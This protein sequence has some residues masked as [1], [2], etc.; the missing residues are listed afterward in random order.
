MPLQS[1]VIPICVTQNS[2]FFGTFLEKILFLTH[3][4]QSNP[5]HDRHIRKAVHLRIPKIRL[6]F[7]F[8]HPMERQI[9]GD[10]GGLDPALILA[11][12]LKINVIAY[13]LFLKLTFDYSRT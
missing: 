1:Q 13:F 4:D 9:F 6:K 5:P 8:R 7:D 11:L 12:C 3:F 10:G 2:C